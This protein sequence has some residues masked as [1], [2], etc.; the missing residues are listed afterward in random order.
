MTEKEKKIFAFMTTR[1]NRL[2]TLPDNKC[3]AEL[4]ELRHGIGHAPGELPMLWGAFLSD[5]PEELYGWNGDPSD[6]QWAVYIALTMFALHQ[7][8]HDISSDMMHKSGA[9]F[10][11]A[12]RMLAP[13]FDESNDDL[14]RIR[15]RFNKILTA[16][17]MPELSH[18]LR[19]MINLLSKD[20]I[21]LDYADLAV[22]LC[23]FAHPENKSKVMLKW[24]QDF[25]RLSKDETN[26]DDNDKDNE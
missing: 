8:G 4:A 11:S 20:G 9:R 26:N 16:A 24:G 21:K 7:Q 3:R 10:G 17:D 19:G 5:L 23:R 15:N 25:C 1:L 22:D 12:V 6:A 2:K 14:K 13:T 18:H